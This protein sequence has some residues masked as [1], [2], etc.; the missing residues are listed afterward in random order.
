M[1]LVAAVLGGLLVSV[2]PA[3]AAPD[4]EPDPASQGTQ[5]V[6][7]ELEGAAGLEAA[8][9][10]AKNAG[11]AKAAEVTA[12]RKNLTGKH[13]ALLA[14]AKDAGVTAKSVRRHTLLLNAVAMTV[15][16]QDLAKL[17][18]LP[19][20]KSVSPAGTS[21]ALDTDANEVVGNPALWAREDPGGAKVTGKGVTV[22]VIDTGVDYTHPDL[23]GGFGEGHKVVGGW[24]FVDNDANPMDDNG[25]GTHVAGIVAGKAAASGGI[26][27]AAPDA[28]LLAY[29]VLGA[30]GSGD[31]SG[32]I[33]AIE[34]AI[35]PANP[36][37]ADII[38]MSLGNS[39]GTASDPL[40][41]AASA[42]VD[43]GA[44]V[45]ASAGN[46]G[47]G[48]WTVGSPAAAP[49]VIAVGAST[50]GIRLPVLTVAG[51]TLQSYRGGRSA[52]PPAAPVT[53]GVVNIG[54]GTAEDWA[55]AG[56]VTG[57][58]VLYAIPPAVNPYDVWSEELETWREA[59]RRG[60]AALVGGVG[61][62]GGPVVLGGKSRANPLQP[63]REGAPARTA[64]A[65]R[66]EV[67][68][69]ATPAESGD[70]LR[71][72][73]LV[74]AG[75]DPETG[76]RLASL[77][78]SGGTLVLGGRDSTDEMASFSSR[79]PDSER[80]GLK[81]EIVAPGVEILSAVPKS[82]EPTGYRRMSGTSMASP[83]AA[84]SAALLRQLHPDR[85]AD[86]L[87]AEVIGSAKPL[88]GPDL[89]SQ[90][91]GRLDTA[92]AARTGLYA[93]PATVSFGL[94]HM[95]QPKVTGS[96]EVTFHNT[97][98][99]PLRGK[100]TVTG[101]A[102]VTP[103]HVDIPAGGT[104]KVTLTV[105]RD[106]PDVTDY[107]TNYLS[108]R[109][110]LTP[111][112]P[113]EGGALTVPYLMAAIPLY[114]DPAEDP[115]NDG[116]T[117]VYVYS[118]TPLTTPPVLTVT[119]PK[120]KAYTKATAPTSDPSYYR[121]DFTG[122]GSGVHTMTARATTSTAVRQYGTG[123]FEV[124]LA[125][126]KAKNWKAVGPNSAVGTTQLAPGAPD[127][128]VMTLGTRPG[129]WL[130]T[131]GG[132]NW[133]QRG[134]TPVSNAL[135]EPSL[136]I[137]SRNPNRWWEAVVSAHPSAFPEGGALMRTEDSGR[138]W[139]RM[140][141]PPA[142]ITELSAD[143][144]T[145]VLLA[146][147]EY[148]GE[149]FVSRD[150]GA[151]WTPV[152]LTGIT[153]YV[154]KSVI[155]GDDLY[156]WAG[157]AIWVIRDF[158]TGA[159][160]PAQKV[161]QTTPRVQLIGGFDADGALLAIKV[162]G[163]DSGL[164]VSRDGGRSVEKTSR[165]FSGLVDVSGGDIYQDDLSGTGA[166]SR[167]GGRTWTTTAQPVPG[168]VVYDYDRWA[169]GSHTI[170]SGGAGLFRSTREGGYR[171]IGVQGESVPA[172]ATFGNQLLAGTSV[173]T[174]RTTV[175]AANPEWGAAERE[176]TTGSNV[177]G[178]QPSAA[179]PKS[180][181]QLVNHL[182]NVVLQKTADAGRTWSDVATR[183]ANGTAFLVDPGNPDRMMISYKSSDSAGLYTTTD[184]G[185]HWKTFDQGRY[186]DTIV[187]DP[188]KPGRI[189]FGGWWG[190]FHSDD[191]GATMTR[192]S[193][194]EVHAIEFT[195]GA[196]V[197]GGQAIRVSKD[198]GKTFT[199][200]DTGALRISVSDLLKV[201]NTLYAG[202]STRWM[203]FTPTGGRGVLRSTDSGLTWH[204]VSRSMPNKDVLSL[205]AS[206][207]GRYLFAGVDQGGV[208]RLELDD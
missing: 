3:V 70:S 118:P 61:G 155:G 66:S 138:S 176:G 171:R 43:A 141:G 174:Y 135:T 201:G 91:S 123:A 195:A 136:V 129:A 152:D 29:K 133:Q 5:R 187:A 202:T 120:G 92:A 86:R 208:H 57:K 75:V 85:P 107:A 168:S 206:P 150:R 115:S 49:G 116:S 82:I 17:R 139:E 158:V 101:P 114:V 47:P 113:G 25:H 148:T 128:A 24:D 160:K 79:G 157:Q 67:L 192:V 99:A 6:I 173:G 110:T 39:A 169:D 105:E 170:G 193:E 58:V 94:A 162:Q 149:R 4:P 36:H 108:G 196:M 106:R 125:A 147:S 177:V 89:Q 35:D 76:G 34:A 184:G 154:A 205:A 44:L 121:A 191:F 126:S 117:T 50:S 156:L 172:L 189:W 73:R 203:D 11:N 166:L 42:A 72:D 83:L 186:Y 1:G 32:I 143:A 23:G 18:K 2:P 197:T 87:R 144:R 90:G 127:R 16:A 194:A 103:D 146:T 22:A 190:L 188:G 142:P 28:E 40:S 26:T 80:L 180:G 165:T 137:D 38:N 161:F 134:H 41:R 60:A 62:G 53:A 68:L 130:T 199:K 96:R 181:W 48:Y 14:G 97:G 140:A 15:G 33:A 7:V 153:G 207:D 27:G 52:N 56:D 10:S 122:L 164:Y 19:G 63:Q 182:Y 55:K 132:K 64:A 77:A 112:T 46:S 167:D 84:G 178:F 8:A 102:T 78:E 81:P 111:E 98:G 37:R 185:A 69:G 12:A 175:P 93:S 20:V 45:F 9:G 204:N 13:D 163:Q 30:N 200:A 131:D 124:T 145:R 119:P 51:D 179:D 159:P 21:R 151:T 59:E 54:M 95:D 183:E 104:A 31:D 88:D 65:G 198:G 71:L 100:V 109:V 74:V